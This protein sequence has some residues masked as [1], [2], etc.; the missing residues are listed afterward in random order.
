VTCSRGKRQSTSRKLKE[1]AEKHTLAVLVSDRLALSGGEG[2][3]DHLR[4]RGGQ[5]ERGRMREKQTDVAKVVLTRL[6]VGVRI[7]E[8]SLRKL[9]EKGEEAKERVED[10]RVNLLRESVDFLTVR[11]EEGEVEN[12]L[13]ATR[14]VEHLD[15]V[16]D[17]RALVR[18]FRLAITPVAVRGRE[19][20]TGTREG[21]GQF[22]ALDGSTGRKARQR[23][24]VDDV[25]SDLEVARMLAFLLERKLEKRL[26][27]GKLTQDL[28]VLDTMSD[29]KEEAHLL[30]GVA[31]VVDEFLLPAGLGELAHVDKSEVNVFELLLG[32]GRALISGQFGYG[33]G[34][35]RC[36]VV[37]GCEREEEE[38]QEEEGKEGKDGRK[39]PPFLL[40]R[41]QCA[42]FAGVLAKRLP[43]LRL[44]QHVVSESRNGEDEQSGGRSKGKQETAGKEAEKQGSGGNSTES[45]RV[46]VSSGRR[47]GGA[48]GSEG[49][50]RQSRSGLH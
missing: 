8:V 11:V 46:V 48:R 28:L 27:D 29:D 32:R 43:S 25:L 9:K 12:L 44:G 39:K 5:H 13:P 14:V 17:V 22:L 15:G 36:C 40:V 21:K 1:K 3:V 26:T 18:F 42:R 24:K 7:S 31:E 19:E 45:K 34:H 23:V 37:E 20:R 4:H 33:G 6:V 38:E 2:I 47:K 50:E 16:A 30:N 49:E 41:P 35:G 10:A